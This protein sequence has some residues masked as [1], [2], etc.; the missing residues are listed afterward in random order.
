MIVVRIVAIT[1]CSLA[2]HLTLGWAWTL[3]A[4]LVGGLWAGRN[5]WFLGAAGTALG[6][7][8]LVGYTAAVASGPF[9]MLV[10]TIGDLAGPVPGL[11]LL[12]ATVLL[13][14]LLGGIGGGIGGQL[15]PLIWERGQ[16]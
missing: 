9:R 12:P 6:W 15:R 14:A 1:V 10:D 7:A 5:G 4:G 16:P 3:G 13:G 11:I 2:L 8:A